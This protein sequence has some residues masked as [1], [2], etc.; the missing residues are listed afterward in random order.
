MRRSATFDVSR[1][2]RYRL[3]RS[4][5]NQHHAAGQVTF[6]ML[7]PS[8][9]DAHQDDPTIQACTAFAKNWGYDQ[10]EVVNLFAYRTKSPSDLIRA[11]NPIGKDNDQYLYL[12]AK[13]A[14][15]II[16]AW[17]NGGALLNRANTVL[18]LLAP[19]QNKLYCLAQ[20]KS[21]YPQHPL[22]IKRTKQPRAF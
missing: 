15:K 1:R 2:Y 11:E 16:L 20:N 19:Y 4:W 7:N 8:R 13:A 5:N 3:L 22:Y 10:L 12:G 6:I 18:E 17:G 9:A 14:R 21:G